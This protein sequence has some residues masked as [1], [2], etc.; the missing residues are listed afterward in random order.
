MLH[1]L[2]VSPRRSRLRTDHDATEGDYR[3]A[4]PGD[5]ARGQRNATQH[6]LVYGDF[7]SCMRSTSERNATGDFATGSRT[8]SR[9]TTV[10]DFAAGG[11]RAS[12]RFTPAEATG[13]ENE[14]PLAA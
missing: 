5:F 2:T 6:D 8:S 11:R 13:L 12:L 4:P 10:A 14:R 1:H 9:P 3:S 7:A